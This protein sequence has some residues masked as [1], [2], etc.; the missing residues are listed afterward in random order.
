MPVRAWQVKY[1]ST[2]TAIAAIAAIADVAT[3]MQPV[4]PPA[5]GARKL[6]SNQTA[7]DG[8]TTDCAPSYVLTTGTAP[9]AEELALMLPL[10][11]AG[12]TVVTADYEGPDSE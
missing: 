4:D 9:P 2:D 8:L 11:A 10:V 12:Y 7:Q 6:V 3:I 1:R 5:A